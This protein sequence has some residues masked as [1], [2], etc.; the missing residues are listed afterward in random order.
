[1]APGGGS[2]GWN[3]PDPGTTKLL[4]SSFAVAL[5]NMAC[6]IPVFMS[7]GPSWKSLYVGTGLGAFGESA[8][9]GTVQR[10]DL[11]QRYR[12]SHAPYV[13]PQYN[14]LRGLI[15][16]FKEKLEVDSIGSVGY[17]GAVS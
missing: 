7:T 10:R 2:S 17:D 16:L 12:M 9:P 5:H 3:L 15:K 14:H 8:L 4:M 11:D 6:H 13:P 1:M